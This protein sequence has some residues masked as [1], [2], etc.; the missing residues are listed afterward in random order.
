M[1][2]TPAGAPPQQAP[3]KASSGRIIAMMVLGGPALAIGGCMLFLANVNFNSGN[4]DNPL[5]FVGGAGFVVGVI[6]FIGGVLWALARWI[7][8]RFDRS[9][10][11]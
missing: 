8:R 4:A 9:K 5:S 11:K 10:A 6:A 3:R 1:T 7:D 2:E